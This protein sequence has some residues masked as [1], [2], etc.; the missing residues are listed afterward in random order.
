MLGVNLLTPDPPY[1][2][3][4][5]QAA[6]NWA[7]AKVDSYLAS[8]YTVPLPNVPAD[9]RYLTADIA[10]YRLIRTI[11]VERNIDGESNYERNYQDS[12]NTLRD[13]SEMRVH[14][15]L[16]LSDQGIPPDSTFV[17][18]SRIGAGGVLSNEYTPGRNS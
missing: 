9:I 13:W 14:P 2:A 18:N 10:I 6:I 12:L 16:A 8:R 11:G 7:S 15:Q 17:A 4:G 1:T 3:S 5:I